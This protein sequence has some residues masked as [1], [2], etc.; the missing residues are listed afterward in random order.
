MEGNSFFRI[1]LGFD[2]LVLLLLGLEIEVEVFLGVAVQ[3][4]GKAGWRF[5]NSDYFFISTACDHI[6]CVLLNLDD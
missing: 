4:V 5:D 2:I 1:C 6:D 3:K